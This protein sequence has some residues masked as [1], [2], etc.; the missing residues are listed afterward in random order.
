MTLRDGKD[1]TM[2]LRTFTDWVAATD[3]AEIP[4]EVME[5]AMRHAR[6]CFGVALAASEHEAGR[7]IRRLN[8]G[9]GGAGTGTANV[10][11]GDGVRTS[12][13]EAAW[14]NGAMGHMLDF[15]DTGFSHPS[16]CIVPAVVALAEEIGASGREAI[17]AIVMGFEAFERL[18]RCTRAPG[19]HRLRDLGFH[20]TSIWGPPAA[21]AGCAKLLGLSG[22]ATARAM[23]IAASSSG[24]LSDQFG[25]WTKG[26]HAGNSARGGLD[27][28]RLASH[29]YLGRPTAIDGPRGL[30][31]MMAGGGAPDIPSISKELGEVWA[32]E[33]PGLRIKLYPVCGFSLRSVEAAI[34]AREELGVDADQISHAV[35]DVHPIALETLRYPRP[36][37]EFE[38]RFSANYPVASALLDGELT[39]ESF[40]TGRFNSPAVL[41]MLDRVE[42]RSRDDWDPERVLHTPVTVTTTDGRT[43]ER[44]V[45]FA[46]GSPENPAS[47]EQ[48]R[49]KFLRCATRAMD[50]TRAERAFTTV[51]EIH[52]QLGTVD[53]GL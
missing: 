40:E 29:G 39:L 6:D 31:T 33:K 47:E 25:T 18:A 2:H 30:I 14:L 41:A 48:H 5:T 7:T 49:T 8:R 52:R 13:E 42:I 3:V 10:W 9:D 34:Q 12:P 1:T 38:A 23:C 20:P 44:F 51:S 19:D 15:D 21:A 4:A 37:N 53:L 17:G 35:I 11:A 28:A 45:P 22:E 26:L 16:S 27:A 43:L 36:A 24:G 50:E 32:I 46:V